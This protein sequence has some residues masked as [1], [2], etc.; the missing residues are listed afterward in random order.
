[1]AKR[2]VRLSRDAIIDC[3]T[4]LADAEGLEAVTIRRLAQENG[5][6]PM[7]MYWHFNDKDSLLDGLA[8]HLIAS[9]KL[10]E[11]GDGMWD[12]QLR[13]IL[14][15]FLDAIRPHPAL[16]GLALRRI[17]VAEPGL[18]LAERVLDLLRQ[19]GFGPEQAAEVGTFLMC[20]VITLVVGDPM[21]AKAA[22]GGDAAA[23]MRHKQAMLQALEP[24]RYPNLIAA[25]PALVS[26]RGQDD[27]FTINIDLLV[28]GV[29][30]TRRN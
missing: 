18:R 12:E 28:Q 6:T 17:L 9:V 22:V 7:A 2:S 16:A 3:A 24:G 25:A 10:P 15:A 23:D 5:V 21:A 13:A 4:A 29:R 30:G 26:C 27:Y 14:V 20:A 11:P 8:E 19:A 1:M